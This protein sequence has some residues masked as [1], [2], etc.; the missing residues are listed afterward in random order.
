[1]YKQVQ[2]NKSAIELLIVRGKSFGCGIDMLYIHLLSCNLF[3]R[4][5]AVSYWFYALQ[6]K[7]NLLFVAWE[8]QI[9]SYIVIRYHIQKHLLLFYDLLFFP[10]YSLRFQNSHRLVHKK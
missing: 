1:V 4:I 10:I 8:T 9:E 7:K 3:F 5:L 2:C 6:N